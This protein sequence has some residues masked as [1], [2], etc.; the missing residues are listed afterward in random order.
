MTTCLLLTQETEEEK[1]GFGT[2]NP[3]PDE[4]SDQTRSSFKKTF[5][6]YRKGSKNCKAY[7]HP[8][9]TQDD[10]ILKP[11]PY[12]MQKKENDTQ[13]VEKNTQKGNCETQ[14]KK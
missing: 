8:D 7:S 4:P 12:L 11:L 9:L 10:S 6:S 14:K 5:I 13:K 1:K 3:N 2:D